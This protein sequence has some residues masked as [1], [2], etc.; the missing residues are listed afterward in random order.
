MIQSLY[1]RV[2]ELFK[3]VNPFREMATG[4]FENNSLLYLHISCK[5]RNA[6]ERSKA[7]CLDLGSYH[8]SLT[9][10]KTDN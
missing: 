4:Q 10:T 1:R 8:I 7:K 6:V 2:I 5:F 9:K 3:L